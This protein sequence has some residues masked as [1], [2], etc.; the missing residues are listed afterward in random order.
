MRGKLSPRERHSLSVQ[1]TLEQSRLVLQ[2][3]SE[4]PFKT[5]FELIGQLNQQAHRLFADGV[6]PEHAQT[7]NISAADLALCVDALG[8]MPFKRVNAL[9]AHLNREILAQCNLTQSVEN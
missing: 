6:D 1:L 9:L 8:D 4:L 3:L 5:V 7:F 2:A